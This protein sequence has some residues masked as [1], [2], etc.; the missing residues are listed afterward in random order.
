MQ[1]TT[2][3]ELG[4]SLCK[5]MI[6]GDSKTLAALCRPQRGSLEQ[7]TNSLLADATLAQMAGTDISDYEITV[8]H[9]PLPG[10]FMSHHVLITKKISRTQVCDVNY[11]VV[12]WK[13]YVGYVSRRK[14]DKEEQD[15]P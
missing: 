3:Q 15:H 6:A 9:K 11:F 2:G 7:A 5:A 8:Q 10:G 1:T 14:S 13:H 4:K 12:D